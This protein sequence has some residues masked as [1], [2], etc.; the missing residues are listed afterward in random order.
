M[1]LD[2]LIEKLQYQ[3]SQCGNIDTRVVSDD[4]C[5]GINKICGV[6]FNNSNGHH[7]VE[8]VV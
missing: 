2:E 5:I 3:Q 8:I 1:K 4:Y 7:R 6:R